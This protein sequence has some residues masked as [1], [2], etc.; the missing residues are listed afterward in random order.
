MRVYMC[1]SVHQLR[2]INLMT[3]DCG[4]SFWLYSFSL[5]LSASKNQTRKNECIVFFLIKCTYEL[6]VCKILNDQPRTVLSS[7]CDSSDYTHITHCY[8]QKWIALL[9]HIF[10][11]FS[12]LL[13]ETN[14][15]VFC[16][17][18]DRVV[19]LTG[20]NV[21]V[22]SQINTSSES[23]V[24]SNILDICIRTMQNWPCREFRFISRE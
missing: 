18:V 4:F 13:V 16:Y 10:F 12:F 22:C 21:R 1:V 11:Y 5:F 2:L 23:C 3:I 9:I 17:G 15:N 20:I 19:N 8:A 14:I 6:Y 7:M 24:C